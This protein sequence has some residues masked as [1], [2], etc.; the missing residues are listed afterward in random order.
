[1][2]K[3]KLRDKSLVLNSLVLLYLVCIFNVSG[4]GTGVGSGPNVRHRDHPLE[5]TSLCPASADRA[6]GKA[7]SA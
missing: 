5:L 1:M 3:K 6:L 2:S 4:C 7:V